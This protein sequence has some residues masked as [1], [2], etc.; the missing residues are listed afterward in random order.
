MAVKT[1]HTPKLAPRAPGA[2]PDAIPIVRREVIGHIHP[3]GEGY[4][5]PIQAGYAAM[6]RYIGD[7]D[8]ADI[9]RLS[10]EFEGVRFEANCAPVRVEWEEVK[11]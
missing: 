7:H 8:P 2:T 5:D 3:H 6:A 4:A 1:G 10:F 9:I 11:G